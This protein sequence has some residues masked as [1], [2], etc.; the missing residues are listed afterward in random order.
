MANWSSFWRMA[1]GRC[2]SKMA[3]WQRNLRTEF[4]WLFP[5]FSANFWQILCKYDNI[6][7]DQ[8]ILV[9][10]L[11]LKSI[12]LRYLIIEPPTRKMISRPEKRSELAQTSTQF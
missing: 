4:Q 7:W 10:H 8:G 1:P 11:S 5:G 3:A 6:R 9:F 2:V 12:E